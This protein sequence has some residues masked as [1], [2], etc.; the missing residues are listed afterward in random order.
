VENA[1]GQTRSA[2]EDFLRDFEE[3]TLPKSDWTHRAHIR[4][5]WLYLQRFS[6]DTALHRVKQGIVRYNSVHGVAGAYHETVT[7]AYVRVIAHRSTL[8]GA[9]STFEAFALANADLLDRA[10]SPLL[11]FY[12]KETLFSDLARARFV[13]PDLRAL[14]SLERTEPQRRSTA[15]D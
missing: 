11:L 15:T 12:R 13:E 14:P 5:A 10:A 6:F 8:R 1:A 4:M 3:T 9:P 2:D 7:E